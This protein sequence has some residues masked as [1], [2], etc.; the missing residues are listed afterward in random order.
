M[1]DQKGIFMWKAGLNILQLLPFSPIIEEDEMY[2][3]WD[4]EYDLQHEPK[5]G[6]K[7]VIGVWAEV[8]QD[9]EV[10]LAFFTKELYDDLYAL[11]GP[12]GE[13][14]FSFH[15]TCGKIV[16]TVIGHKRILKK[17]L[18]EGVKRENGRYEAESAWVEEQ[19]KEIRA[20]NMKIFEAKWGKLRTSDN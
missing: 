2:E 19:N 20:E 8:L 5:K 7:K 13:S 17:Y 9:N 1:K 11:C 10:K 12:D 15:R 14:V 3:R 18:A 16:P 4:V 6:Y